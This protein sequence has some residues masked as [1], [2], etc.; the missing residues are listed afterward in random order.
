MMAD[1][2][3]RKDAK[4]DD[5]L[6]GSEW[7]LGRDWMLPTNFQSKGDKYIVTTASNTFLDPIKCEKG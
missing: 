3:T 4:I 1:I 2:G 5:V 7:I 6:P